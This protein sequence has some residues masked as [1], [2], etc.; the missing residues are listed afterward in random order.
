MGLQRKS[1]LSPTIL[2]VESGYF[3]TLTSHLA[4]TPCLEVWNILSKIS[5]MLED[6]YETKASD[7]VKNKF[8]VC[9]SL[10]Y[11]YI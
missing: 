3:S 11:G 7:T 1:N 9:N 6:L 8:S 4:G 5:K 2:E 10:G